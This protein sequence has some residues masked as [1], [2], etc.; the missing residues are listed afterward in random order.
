MKYNTIFALGALLFIPAF[1]VLFITS[2]ALAHMLINGHDL[3]SKIAITWLVS[4]V[5]S[6]MA[7]KAMRWSAIRNR[8]A[9]TRAE[10]KKSEALAD[11]AG[12]HI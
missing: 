10:L 11:R 2:F 5:F 4:A 6:T 1:L 8:R 12:V 9:R 3:P 7:Y